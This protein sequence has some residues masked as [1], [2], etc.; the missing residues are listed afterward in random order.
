[1]IV[2]FSTVVRK[3]SLNRGGELVKL[4]WTTKKICRRAPMVP[5]DPDVRDPNP[6]GS[7]RGGRGILLDNGMIYAAAYHTIHV[8][9]YEL[10]P[11]GAVSN[12][13]FAGLH[14]LCWDNGNIWTASTGIDA[15][16]KVDP[17]GRIVDEWWPREDA[18]LARRFKLSPLDIDK[19]ADNRVRHVATGSNAPGHVHLNAVAML[20]GRPLALLNRLGCVARL[21]P[22]EVLIEDPTLRGAHNLLVTPDRQLLINDTVN[23]NVRVYDDTGTLRGMFDLRHLAPVRRI[24]RR[25]KLRDAGVWLARSGRPRSLFNRLFGQLTAAR[26]VFVRGLA[27]TGYGTVLVG[28]SPATILELDLKTGEMIDF[29]VF[30]RDVHCCVHGIVCEAAVES[31][32]AADLSS[33]RENQALANSNR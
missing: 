30:S 4:D 28:L 13:L 10:I 29:F 9:D 21:R 27:S 16:I 26:P 2:Y 24:L 11:R 3:A 22:T 6:R 19:T 23:R 8:F 14:E 12:F 25:H 15:A 17:S 32:V 18:L 20:H 33:V 5:A 1:M 7:T 31:P